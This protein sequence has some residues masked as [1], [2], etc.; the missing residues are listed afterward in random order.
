MAKLGNVFLNTVYEEKPDKS[1]KT[2]E[3]PIEDGSNIT[4]HIHREAVTMAISGIVTGP[5]AGTRRKQLETYMNKGTR[6]KYVY[7]NVMNGMIIENF[8][9]VH[10]ANIKN[11]FKFSLTMKQ[12]KIAKKARVVKLAQTKPVTNGGRR[13]PTPTPPKRVYTVVRG[14]NLTKIGRK[15]K[16]SWRTIYNKNRK[17]IGNN[18]NLIYPGQ[19]LVI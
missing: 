18:P 11:G 5:D 7:R 13:Q 12:V 2:S 10:D 8:S 3:H 15:F 1:I 6:L 16:V 4:D 19:K 14:D 9:T 17:V